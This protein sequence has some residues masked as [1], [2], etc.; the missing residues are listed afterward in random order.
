VYAGSVPYLMMA[1]TTVAGWQMARALMA[2]E[3][4]L[5]QGGDDAF[6]AAKVAT[7]RFYAEHI[8]N[9]VPGTADSIVNGADSVTAL[10]LEAF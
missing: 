2:A 5:G 3:E 7:A 6:L 8:L 9:K 4:G 1:G 10:A